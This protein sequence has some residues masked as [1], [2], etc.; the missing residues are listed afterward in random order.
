MSAGGGYAPVRVSEEALKRGALDD[1]F[2]ALMRFE[3]ARARACY[4]QAEA[5]FPRIHPRGRPTLSW[6]GI[7]G[8]LDV[9]ERSDYDVFTRRAR[10]ADREE[11]IHPLRRRYP[12]ILTR[13]SRPEW[14]RPSKRP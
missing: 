6:S 11:A 3:A 2:R 12:R 5:L 14:D 8:I 10:G 9:I 13:R 4:D 7:W 1:A